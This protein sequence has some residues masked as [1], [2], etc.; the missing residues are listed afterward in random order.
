MDPNHQNKKTGPSTNQIT[1]PLEGEVKDDA[2]QAP[3]SEGLAQPILIGIIV[4]VTTLV[5]LSVICAV[6]VFWKKSQN[7]KRSRHSRIDAEDEDDGGFGLTPDLGKVMK[8][9]RSNSTYIDPPGYTGLSR[10]SSHTSQELTMEE[11]TQKSKQDMLSEQMYRFSKGMKAPLVD[12]ESLFSTESILAKCAIGATEADPPP[13]PDKSSSKVTRRV[14]NAKNRP[15]SDGITQ[16][17]RFIP[18]LPPK[19]RKMQNAKYQQRLSTN[20]GEASTTPEGGTIQTKFV[21]K[22]ENCLFTVAEDL[23]YDDLPESRVTPVLPPKHMPH[24]PPKQRINKSQNDLET[25]EQNF[26]SSISELAHPDPE[27]CDYDDPPP[28][29]E[30]SSNHP[31]EEP[32]QDYDQPI[33]YSKTKQPESEDYDEPQAYSFYPLREI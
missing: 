17:K 19:K 25:I 20:T 14:S 27:E 1:L 23:D 3:P 29:N 26:K 5:V 4:V 8:Y 22:S 21:S 10:R 30:G 6:C 12:A 28:R 11:V 16:D 24:L 31:E 13:F 33:P 15:Q 32:D 9:D 7:K 2:S 18:K